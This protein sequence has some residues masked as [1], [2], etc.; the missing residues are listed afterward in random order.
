[1]SMPEQL[2]IGAHPL[3]DR[4]P[5]R[6][7]RVKLRQADTRTRGVAPTTFWFPVILS[8]LLLPLAFRAGGT[9]PADLVIRDG[10]VVTADRAFRV[11]EAMAVRK[12][13]IVAVGSNK[14]IAGLVGPG[15]RIVNLRGRMVLPGLIDSHVHA[16]GASRYE[17][18]HEIP[19]MDTIADVL[20]YIRKRTRVVP[21]GEWITL[22]QVFITRLK[23]QRYP[24]RMPNSI[25]WLLT[26]RSLFA[27]DPTA[28]SILW[29][30]RKTA[31]TK[32]LQREPSRTYCRGSRHGGTYGGPAAVP[33]LCSRHELNS[34]RQRT[35]HRRSWT[36]S[37]GRAAARL[38]P[39]GPN[40]RD[41]SQ[42]QHVGPG[43][44]RAAAARQVV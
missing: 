16:G 9:E 34:T 37:V 30:S 25:R 32:R 33:E 13:R 31:S 18:S 24:T 28:A 21:R 44:V 40:R 6:L 29:L 23:E 22:R 41:R 7:N 8:I 17:A 5:A 12:G 11:V 10:R 15:T 19:P 2:Y 26:T 43:P 38:Q 20:A 27:P 4:Y 42:L 39:L 14:D 3:P 1:M 36:S 35:D